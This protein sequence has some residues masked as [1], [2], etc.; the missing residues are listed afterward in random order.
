MNNIIQNNN[1]CAICM[2]NLKTNTMLTSCGHKYHKACINIW[3]NTG[4]TTCPICRKRT[5]NNNKK[6]TRNIVIEVALEETLTSNVR[7]SVVNI[8]KKI[9]KLNNSSNVQT[10]KRFMNSLFDRTRSRPVRIPPNTPEYN[11]IVSIKN[12][13]LESNLTRNEERMLNKFSNVIKE[14]MN[15]E[16]L[17]AL[18]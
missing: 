1:L 9:G 14:Y 8:M 5:R 13:I 4:A 16:T 12:A 2:G 10:M 11:K 6:T 7:N 15:H 3:H 18:E 17:F